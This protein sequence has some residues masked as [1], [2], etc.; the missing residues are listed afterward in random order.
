MLIENRKYQLIKL[1]L[2]LYD[3]SKKLNVILEIQHFFKFIY[4]F[5]YY[6]IIVIQYSNYHLIYS[7]LLIVNILDRFSKIITHPHFQMKMIHCI[8]HLFKDALDLLES[9]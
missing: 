5:I 4:Y 8:Q 7:T 3:L 6:I 9:I 1:S 2:F